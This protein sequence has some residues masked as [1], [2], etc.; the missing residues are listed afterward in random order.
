MTQKSCVSWRDSHNLQARDA[1]PH[2]CI[3]PPFLPP[4]LMALAK[5]RRNSSDHSYAL[6]TITTNFVNEDG[7]VGNC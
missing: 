5:R 7:E 1:S 4:Q 6:Q 2:Y 3:I